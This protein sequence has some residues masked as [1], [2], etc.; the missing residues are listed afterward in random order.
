MQEKARNVVRAVVQ[1]VH[2]IGISIGAGMLMVPGRA[3]E[4]AAAEAS[5]A[6]SA[7]VAQ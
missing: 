6:R 7:L 1:A 3:T 5:V 4:A 2:R